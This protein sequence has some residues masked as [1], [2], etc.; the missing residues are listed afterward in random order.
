VE[1]RFEFGGTYSYLAAAQIEE[2]A[3]TADI[4]VLWEPFLLGPI[5]AKRG[6]DDSPFNVYPAG[7]RA[8]D[9]KCSELRCR[10]RA[11][12]GNDRLEDALA[13]AGSRTGKARR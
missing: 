6:W 9:L 2:I 3:A 10:R 11:F 13:W 1:F 4:P 5:F 7:Q 8:L 12:L